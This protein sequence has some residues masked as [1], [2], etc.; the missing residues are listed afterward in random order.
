M[1]KEMMKQQANEIKEGVELSSAPKQE[2]VPANAGVNQGFVKYGEAVTEAKLNMFKNITIKAGNNFMALDE[3]T[4]DVSLPL[5][6]IKMASVRMPIREVRDKIVGF[7]C[8]VGEMEFDTKSLKLFQELLVTKDKT[9]ILKLNKNMLIKG[10]ETGLLGMCKNDPAF[11][12]DKEMLPSKLSLVAEENYKIKH[13]G[14]NLCVVLDPIKVV[15]I[16]VNTITGGKVDMLT[17]VVK[18]GAPVVQNGY[19]NF[20]FVVDNSQLINANITLAEKHLVCAKLQFSHQMLQQYAAKYLRTLIAE[21]TD[22]PL[23]FV[24]TAEIAAQSNGYEAMSSQ[25]GGTGSDLQTIPL[26]KISNDFKSEMKNKTK[27]GILDLLIKKSS[28]QQSVDDVKVKN[29][30]S[31]LLPEGKVYSYNIGVSGEL[32]IMPSYKKLIMLSLFENI[33]NYRMDIV[34]DS[35]TIGVNISL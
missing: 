30:Y 31:A 18:V 34:D 1:K 26:I 10:R 15:Q 25:Y 7:I 2:V 35:R 6:M 13:Y 21:T 23:V 17:N 29:T 3:E 28:V 22:E 20:A 32:A 24:R 5:S 33:R 27:N 8:Q 14:D 4:A 12:V 9:L 11:F 16:L 19:V